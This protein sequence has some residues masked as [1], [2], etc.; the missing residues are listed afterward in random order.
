MLGSCRSPT[1]P[2]C[3]DIGFYMIPNDCTK[4]LRCGRA[5]NGT[6]VGTQYDC[7]K[8]T[9]FNA[10]IPVCDDPNNMPHDIRC[11]NFRRRSG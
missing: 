2:A 6:I 5:P 9:L 7:P 8:G 11:R 3:P 10:K 4:F 1:L